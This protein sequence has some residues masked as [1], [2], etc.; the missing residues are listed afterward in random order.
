MLLHLIR[1]STTNESTLGLLLM[2]GKFS[3]YTIE[4][5]WHPE[6]V[7]GKTRIPAGHYKI[8]LRDEG[9]MTKKY[10]EVYGDM[11][12]GMLWLQDVPG[13][14]WIYIHTG[15]TAEHSEGCILVGNGASSNVIRG[16]LISASRAAY[17]SIYPMIA[18]AVRGEGASI[19]IS[20]FA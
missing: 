7:V 6:K 13:F 5:A 17:R 12:Q 10:A 8:H 4:D 2:D 9:G 16:G 1:Y 19:R 18:R 14:E 15:N 3:C 11:H 20:D